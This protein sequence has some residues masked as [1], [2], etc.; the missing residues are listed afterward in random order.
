MD[1]HFIIDPFIETV[2]SSN[3]IIT[4]YFRDKYIEIISSGEVKQKNQELG[5]VTTTQI[6]DRRIMLKQFFSSIRV[7]VLHN[8]NFSS[9]KEA[10]IAYALNLGFFNGDYCIIPSRQRSI[11]EEIMDYSIEWSTK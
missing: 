3:V 4:I 1:K 7:D 8:Q 9:I 5:I 11:L 10:G 2:E 6:D